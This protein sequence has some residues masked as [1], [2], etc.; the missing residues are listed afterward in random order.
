MT[1]WWLYSRLDLC[2]ADAQSCAGLWEGRL[3]KASI[4]GAFSLLL[5]SGAAARAD[6]VADFIKAAQD[7]EHNGDFDQAIPIYDAILK[8]YPKEFPEVYA[9]RGEDRALADD[10]KGAVADFTKALELDND[11]KNPV[12][13]HAKI[14]EDRADAKRDYDEKGAVADYHLA[15]KDHPTDSFMIA[16]MAEAELGMRACADSNNDYSQAIALAK[17]PEALY[18]QNR[19]AARLCIGD[20]A[21]SYSDFQ[22]AVALD[23]KGDP[24]V[25][26]S[27]DYLDAWALGV[28]LG[29]KDDADKALTD[30]LAQTRDE[31]S[32]E[33]AIGAYF[34]GKKDAAAV[35]QKALEY[36]KGNPDDSWVSY[37]SYFIGLKQMADGDNQAAIASLQKVLASK[38]TL[39][40]TRIQA[41]SWIQVLGGN[42]SPAPATGAPA[43]KTQATPAKKK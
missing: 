40:N 19:A 15:L 10:A 4:A 23:L 33:R 36:A 28:K 16:D 31:D 30:Q 27:D 8:E 35:T 12:L 34:L 21:N 32:L 42:A 18:F 24:P 3:M 14:Y 26:F 9:Y 25:L 20:V 5:L 6:T 7:K 29:R 43:K 17:E 39:N 37:G 1:I 2:R 38:S 41:R 11:P 13:D 22:A